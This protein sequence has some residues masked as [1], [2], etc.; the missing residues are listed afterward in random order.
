MKPLLT[1]LFAA[2]PLVAACGDDDQSTAATTT[3]PAASLPGAG[4]Q[5]CI[6]EGQENPTP[7]YV[8]L[9]LE[10]AEALAE[11]NGLTLRVVGEDGECFPI[12]MDLRDDRVNVELADGTVVAA[13]IF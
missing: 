4:G 13:A 8:G 7:E 12:T 1:L 11:E 3:A 10:D 5:P 2:L 9:S 6:A